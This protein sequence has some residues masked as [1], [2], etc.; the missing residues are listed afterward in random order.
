MQQEIIIKKRLTGLARF[1]ILLLPLIDR[2]NVDVMK[3]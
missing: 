1:Y 3:K 2:I